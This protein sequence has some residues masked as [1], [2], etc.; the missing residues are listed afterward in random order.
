MGVCGAI[1]TGAAL[2]AS[3]H[4]LGPGVAAMNYRTRLLAVQPA[5]PGVG[6][7]VVDDG[8]HVIARNSTA[9]PL[10]ID[11]YAG[12]PYLMIDRRGSWENMRSPS[13]YLNRTFTPGAVPPL[14]NA[15]ATPDWHR[16]GGA[17]WVR[18][19][20][21]RLHWMAAQ[22]PAQVRQNPSRSNLISL[23]R[24]DAHY[25]PRPVEVT[26]SLAWVPGQSPTRWVALL[27]L[28]AVA[29]A[30]AMRRS[31]GGAVARV[32]L[33]VLV[34]IDVVR[35]VG[36]VAGR[37]GTL[38]DR[39]A[40]MPWRGAPELLVWAAVAGAVALG[41]RRRTLVNYV[42]CFS[43]TAVLVLDGAV[44]LPALWRSQLLAWHPWWLERAL[45]AATVGIAIGVIAGG[46]VA[47]LVRW[48]GP[49]PRR[50]LRAAL[51][52]GTALLIS[53]CA[54]GGADHGSSVQLTTA[55]VSGLG[56]VLTDQSGQ[57]LYMFVPDRRRAV[58]CGEL[59]QGTWPPLTAATGRQ[60]LAS[61]AAK[62]GLIGRVPNPAGGAPVVTYRGWPLYTYVGDV[63]SG[64]ATGQGVDLNGGLWFALAPDGSVVKQAYES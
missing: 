60:V 50:N 18:W 27:A 4:S 25:G 49:A 53:G 24:I 7:S 46:L 16:L 10:V 62:Q 19:H 32:V 9:T 52:A 12:E 26:G 22:P 28:A 45:I 36:L 48:S 29:T 11:G 63:T 23:W 55:Q 47:L 31:R 15:H 2:P 33:A 51:A 39:L 43:G 14:A 44:S 59:C 30:L 58:T 61:G 13:T 17:D 20:D 42:A 40:A 21:H 56:P 5:I 37:G 54:G 8:L 3:A 1:L 38:G 57:V 64:T 34:L 41:G 35:S 6:F